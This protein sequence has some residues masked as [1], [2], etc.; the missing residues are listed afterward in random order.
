MCNVE[1]WLY[2]ERDF[3]KS[4]EQSGSKSYIGREKSMLKGKSGLRQ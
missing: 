4:I 2:K 3:W 1:M